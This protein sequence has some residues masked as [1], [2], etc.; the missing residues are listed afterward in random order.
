MEMK[1]LNVEIKG[2]GSCR[3]TALR[4]LQSRG[5]KNFINQRYYTNA[6]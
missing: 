2:P 6:S 3:K 4:A 5:F 1:T